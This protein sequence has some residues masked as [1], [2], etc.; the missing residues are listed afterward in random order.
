MKRILTFSLLA[1]LATFI[2]AGCSKNGY[3]DNNNPDVENGVVKYAPV[4][5]NYYAVVQLFDSYAFIETLDQSANKWPIYND[6]L[7]GTFYKGSNNK[8]YNQTA[9]V[10]TTVVVHDFY[11]TEADADNALEAY[12][13]KYG[14]AKQQQVQTADSTSSTRTIK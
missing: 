7:R 8:V 2:F 5:Y 13:A 14:Y 6:V 12:H 10:W 1:V 9:Q 3:N 11:N 4:G